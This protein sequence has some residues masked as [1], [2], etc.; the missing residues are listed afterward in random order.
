M[1]VITYREALRH[2][3]AE[4]LERDPFSGHLRVNSETATPIPG[5]LHLK[6]TVNEGAVFGMGQGKQA[7]VAP[8]LKVHGLE[9][10]RVCDRP[11]MPYVIE[12][13]TNAPAITIAEKG[14]DLSRGR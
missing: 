8:D 1:P 6:V 4:E 3:M 2:A 12:A 13:N 14:A 9:G 7:V 11:V 10:L 5:W